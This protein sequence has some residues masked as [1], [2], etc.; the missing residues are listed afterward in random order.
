MSVETTR[1]RSARDPLLDD[2]RGWWRAPVTRRARRAWNLA[3]VAIVAA[4]MS[5]AFYAQFILELE[6][7]PLCMFQRVALI[8]LG[9]V[10]LVAA[11]HAPVGKSARAYSV[12][13]FLAAG[14]GIGIAAW[15]VRLQYFPLPG[16]P[17]CTPGT[18]EKL[19][20]TVSSFS[21]GIARAFTPTG[22]CS[23]INWDF[24]GLSMPAWLLLW[25]TALGALAVAA[26]WKVLRA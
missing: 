13:G 23:Q 19:M 25:F 12:L 14:T 3:G 24:L 8:S 6:V 15:H 7:C 18:W 2:E 21:Q 9:V 20:G 16:L 4:L 26:N 22:E 10:M 5:Y 1:G 11:L 17:Q